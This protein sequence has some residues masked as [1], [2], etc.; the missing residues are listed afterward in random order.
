MRLLSRKDGETLLTLLMDDLPRQVLEAVAREGGRREAQLVSEIL[1]WLP[2]AVR[3]EEVRTWVSDVLDWFIARGDVEK[4]FGGRYHCVPPYLVG[5][6]DDPQCAEL[7]LCGDP[8]AEP[9]LRQALQSLGM[10]LSYKV[11]CSE[12][13]TETEDTTLRPMPPVGLERFIPLQSGLRTEVIQACESPGI[14]IVQPKDLA[15][16]LPR[17][18]E[19]LVPAERDL[20]ISPTSTGL[21]EVYGPQTQDNDRWRPDADWRTGQAQLI[22]WRPS[23]DWCGERSARIFYH[24]GGGR[25][26]ELGPEAASLWQLYLDADAGR[27]RTVWWDG[28]RLW[29]PRML[30]VATHQWLRLLAGR[31][32]NFRG[33]WLVLEMNE[34]LASMAGTTLTDTL[35]LRHEDGRPPATVF[36]RSYRRSSGQ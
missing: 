35:G 34:A 15:A 9:L 5:D 28:T 22:R 3:A 12:M 32:S 25:V 19:V 17:L 27:P 36:W 6:V 33:R 2:R 23:D 31:Q 13:D 4:G 21:W 26:A 29:V 8:R 14:V 7:S 18:T 16:A 24:A 20:A 11:I 10:T 1:R 30:P